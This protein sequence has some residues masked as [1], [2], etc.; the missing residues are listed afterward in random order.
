MSDE[1]IVLQK[2][3]KKL[4]KYKA[5][6]P[7]GEAVY[8]GDTRHQQYKDRPPLKLYK[9]LDHTDPKRRELYYKRHPKDYDKYSA[10]YFAKKK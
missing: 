10:A 1:G 3:D 6:L 8:F 4:N 5:S 7:N 2:S 9:H